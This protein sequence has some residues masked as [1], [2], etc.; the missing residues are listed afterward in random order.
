MDYPLLLCFFRKV[1]AACEALPPDEPAFKVRDLRVQK[2]YLYIDLSP[3]PRLK[4]LSG[5]EFRTS[6]SLL[7]SPRTRRQ[8][9]GFLLLNSKISKDVLARV[10]PSYGKPHKY[11]ER[12]KKFLYG[13]YL[14]SFDVLREWDRIFFWRFKNPDPTLESEDFFLVMELTGRWANTLLISPG[15]GD[16]HSLKGS[17]VLVSFKYFK[18]KRREIYNGAPYTVPPSSSSIPSYMS[19][20]EDFSY[21]RRLLQR[22]GKVLREFESASNKIYM[23]ENLFNGKRFLSCVDF[24]S[25][26]LMGEFSSS[27]R[28]VEEFNS[29]FDAFRV[30]YGVDLLASWDSLE[31]EPSQSEVLRGKETHES[32]R[33]FVTDKGDFLEIRIDG[34][35]TLV[36]K[37]WK[38]NLEILRGANREWVWLHPREARG[39]HAV[40]QS[41]EPDEVLISKVAGI[42]AYRSGYASP[43]DVDLAR[44][45]HI[46]PLKGARGTVLYRAERTVK[47]DPLVGRGILDKKSH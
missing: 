23:V 43:V 34:V 2:N 10:V 8:K 29:L 17:R 19:V 18:G 32:G 25:S 47:G 31:K 41:S 12:W 27:F 40:I 13:A 21:E 16:I 9:I 37:N 22:A 44:V 35:R 24:S 26:E 3:N 20:G 30:V 6:F 1:M 15:D 33:S 45:K 39:A 7:F 4:S 36:G 46:K 28:V 11:S 42:V 38:G 5:G 14:F